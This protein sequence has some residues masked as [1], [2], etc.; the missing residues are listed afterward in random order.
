M[1]LSCPILTLGLTD[2]ALWFNHHHLRLYWQKLRPG[3]RFCSLPPLH[4]L[5]LWRKELHIFQSLRHKILVS[6]LFCF[7]APT[8]NMQR[9]NGCSFEGSLKTI[10][11]PHFPCQLSS[12]HT[13]VSPSDPQL[14]FFFFFKFLSLPFYFLDPIF[15]PIKSFHGSNSLVISPVSHPLPGL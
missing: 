11:L 10:L 4:P 13:W 3:S 2:T 8:E 14:S 5:S 1:P 6:S 7:S 15:T 9:F 12:C